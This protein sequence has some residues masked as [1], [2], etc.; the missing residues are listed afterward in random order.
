MI[1]RSRSSPRKPD[2]ILSERGLL[3]T[4]PS[5]HPLP[6]SI[7]STSEEEAPESEISS[8]IA[9]SCLTSDENASPDVSLASENV[10]PRKTYLSLF[11]S[12]RHHRP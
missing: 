7:L 8:D 1:T 10:G 3:H 11:K 9:S 12:G 5:S 6:H 2:L 4:L